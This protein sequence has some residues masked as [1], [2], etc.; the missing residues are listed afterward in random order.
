M[1]STI[2]IFIKS[3]T[4][5]KY[6]QDFLD[7]K[8]FFNRLSYFK[9]LE[10]EGSAT[11]GDKYEAVVDW[12]Q[13]D[14]VKLTISFNGNSFDINDLTAPFYAQATGLNDMHVFCLYAAH[15]GNLVDTEVD[16]SET[17]KGKLRVPTELSRFGEHAVII[18]EP[19]SFIE[20]V[21]S[22]IK[23]KTQWGT[24]GLVEYYDPDTFS[25]EFSV[26]DALFRKREEFSYQS[27]YRFA[28]ST[29]TT[30]SDSISLDIGSLRDIAQTLSMDDIYAGIK[31]ELNR[32]EKF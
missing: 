19:A 1:S 31:L 11:R 23:S 9:G 29:N 16:G 15:S 24:A 27:E 4:R 14:K 21:A 28:F 6:S 2:F 8:L 26:R 12:R 7:G 30:G 18:T 22:A 13:A 17:I 32:P 5:K 3:F 20:R 25:G 10:D